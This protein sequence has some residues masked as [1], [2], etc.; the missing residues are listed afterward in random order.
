VSDADPPDELPADVDEHVARVFGEAD[1]KPVFYGSRRATDLFEP[2]GPGCRGL[3]AGRGTEIGQLLSARPAKLRF[4]TAA[5][6]HGAGAA[7]AETVD[8]SGE[9]RRR[10]DRRQD[11][12]SRHVYSQVAA[13]RGSEFGFR[14]GADLA[15]AVGYTAA[16]LDLVPAETLARFVGLGRP[17]SLGAARSGWRCV[18]VGCG[19]G[20]DVFVAAGQVG[21]TGQVIGV[22]LSP[23]MVAM[24]DGAAR[25]AGIGQ[26]AAVE[27]SATTLPV[28]D[29]SVDLVTANGLLVLVR[30]PHDALVE[31]R[32]ALRPGGVVR[33]ADTVFGDE[34]TTA[35]ADDLV[36]WN[37]LGFG[38][39][40]VDEVVAQLVAA[41]FVDV[42]VGPAVDP[43][44]PSVDHAEI[45]GRSFQATR[46]R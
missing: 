18:D 37:R 8:R 11:R 25:R 1:D 20:V 39:P 4:L 3:G 35:D 7:G 36:F 30:E 2:F 29:G 45:W 9:R 21:P 42:E 43:F 6:L 22:D 34:T 15:G 27:A 26:V 24:V 10:H 44:D 12:V 28:A 16:E 13:G 19:V 17:W 33:F 32:R 41:G 40:F 23:G 38:R 31:I 46:P 5:Q 14:H